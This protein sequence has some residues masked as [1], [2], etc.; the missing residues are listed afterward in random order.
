MLAEIWQFYEELNKFWI[1]EIRHVVDAVKSCRIDPRD[2]E[3][4]NNFYSSLKRTIEFWKVCSTALL[5]VS[6]LIKI[7]WSESATER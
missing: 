1:E 4:W 5:Y 7:P 6:Q 3:R 2:F